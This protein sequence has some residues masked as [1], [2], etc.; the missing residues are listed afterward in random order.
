LTSLDA[1]CS[2]K[3]VWPATADVRLD[4][5][6][7]ARPD[8]VGDATRLPFA[9]GS[10]DTVY[11]DPPHFIRFNHD[12]AWQTQFGPNGHRGRRRYKRFSSWPNKAAWRAFVDASLR[13]FHRVLKPRGRLVWKIPDGTRSHGRMAD[14]RDVMNAATGYFRLVDFE[15]HLSDGL[16]SRSNVRMGKRVTVVFELTLERRRRRTLTS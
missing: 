10:F 8:V 11:C 3:R 7:R 5:D 6:P 2:S 15:Y 13:E 9:N 16:L 1:T 12:R 4:I 14:R